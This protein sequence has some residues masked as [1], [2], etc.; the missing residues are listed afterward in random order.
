[1]H[2][3]RTTLLC[4]AVLA[5]T[6]LAAAPGPGPSPTPTGDPLARFYRQQITWG[7]CAEPGP[8]DM[9]CGTLTVP[10]DY[11]RPAKGTVDLVVSR[12]PA[13]G[14]H[15]RGPL[16]LNFGG[17]G[18]PGVAT[19]AVA[20]RS[21]ADLRE[22]YDLVAFDPRG[23]GQ[24]APISC[25]GA[26]A[27]AGT[28]TTADEQLQS[29]RAT[30]TACARHSG[31]V[32][33][34]VGTANVARDMDVLRQAL[35]RPRLDYL[36]FSYGTRV[37]AA[38]AAEFP[39]RTGRMAL[40]GVDNLTEPLTEQARDTAEGQQRAL[41]DFLTW[42]THRP[43]CVYGTNTRTAKERVRALI[44]NLD[45]E[46]LV[47]HDGS[48]F[49]GQ[50]T[51]VAIGAALYAQAN[52]PLLAD[53]LA[54]VERQHDPS[55]LIELAGAVVPDPEPPYEPDPTPSGSGG[56]DG[57]VGTTEVPADNMDAALIAVNCADDPDG[58]RDGSTAAV[59]RKIL[60]L[61]AEFQAASPV[62]GPAQ[63]GTVL[64]CYGRPA[65]SDFVRK[66]DRPGAPRILL[67][68]TRGDPATPY[69]WT[70]ETAARLGNVTVVDHKGDG[71]TG[72]GA[73]ACVRD[74]V[75]AYLVDGTLPHGTRSC[76][77]GE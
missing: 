20:A 47:G 33:P 45:A 56:T 31:P 69:R 68:G 18:V 43:D 25:G 63:L 42:C 75:N 57:V 26:L 60:S 13:S 53:A 14:P 40:D 44:R 35:G 4:A 34:Y 48:Q 19:L 73:S 72:Y 16:V 41:D 10:L 54:R 59:V 7:R 65:G 12:I 64:A 76:P 30:A 71:H 28:G 46:P 21:F 24:S 51:V 11:A 49:T 1:M 36:G 58:L 23:V 29:L 8:A 38:Y 62:F 27:T 55:G 5:A 52:W 17:P 2:R 61:Q 70:E 15:R 66:I 50:D 6:A 32:L 67:V 9:R 3:P 77:A 37:G 22:A 39:H 74:K